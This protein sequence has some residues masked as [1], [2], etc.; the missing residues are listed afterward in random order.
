MISL[1]GT[2][3]IRRRSESHSSGRF[4]FLSGTGP[5]GCLH[6]C[7]RPPSRS[8][9]FNSPVPNPAIFVD[10]SVNSH[11]Y[12]PTREYETATDCSNSTVLPARNAS[13]RKDTAHSDR[14][15]TTQKSF[16]SDKPRVYSRYNRPTIIRIDCSIKIKSLYNSKVIFQDRHINIPL[17]SYII[18]HN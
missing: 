9:V 5:I 15:D 13:P 2:K 14:Q 16:S 3:T 11:S 18:V 8:L 10:F 7:T 12:S 1:V 6:S 17:V 4:W